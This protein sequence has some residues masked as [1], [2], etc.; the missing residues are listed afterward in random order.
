M[1]V[2]N[3]SRAPL[4][5]SL[6]IGNGWLVAGCQHPGLQLLSAQ[7]TVADNHSGGH[8][9]DRDMQVLTR[10]RAVG[11]QRHVGLLRPA[12]RLDNAGRVAQNGAKFR[13]GRIIK[14]RDSY[15]VLLRRDDQGPEI[16]HAKCENLRPARRLTIEATIQL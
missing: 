12:E 1:I 9:L 4:T 16:H 10:A 5:E 2:R 8:R 13:Y 11:P 6:Y 14:V 15:D 3:S 7:T